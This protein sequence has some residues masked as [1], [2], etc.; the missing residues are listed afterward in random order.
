MELQDIRSQ[1]SKGPQN[2]GTQDTH[3]ADRQ[4][5]PDDEQR[6][7]SRTERSSIEIPVPSFVSLSLG[8]AYFRS[9]QFDEAEHQYR[10]AIA[11]IPRPAKP[12]TTSPSS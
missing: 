5:D 1:V 10:A 9:E 7:R 4:R 6:V 11:P 3:A 8:S 2:A 12:T